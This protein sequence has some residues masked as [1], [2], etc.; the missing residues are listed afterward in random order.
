MHELAGNLAWTRAG[1]RLEPRLAYVREASLAVY[2]IRETKQQPE[3]PTCDIGGVAT[4]ASDGDGIP[5]LWAPCMRC[6][7]AA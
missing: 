2:T 3:Q 5:G 6:F 4:E 7:V 1:R